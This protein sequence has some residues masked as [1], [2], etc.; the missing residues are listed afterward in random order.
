MLRTVD[1]WFR[2]SLEWSR[3]RYQELL[4]LHMY[5]SIL[6]MFTER[7][8][9]PHTDSITAG[10]ACDTGRKSQSPSKPDHAVGFRPQL[11]TGTNVT[12]LLRQC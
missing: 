8:S 2:N 12:E 5:H 1:I 9:V 7:I 3:V 11:Y 10:I 6:R 4:T